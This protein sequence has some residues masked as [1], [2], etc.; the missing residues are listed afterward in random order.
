MK[1]YLLEVI[2]IDKNSLV[3]FLLGLASCLLFA[4][5]NFF[6]L[7]FIIFPILA[8]RLF[9]AQTYSKT[10]HILLYFLLGFYFSNYY[11]ISFSFLV[12]KKYILLFPIVFLLI[13]IYFSAVSALFLAL[14]YHIK[15]YLKLD[16]KGFFWFFSLL[17]FLHEYLRG[18]IV[19]LVDFKGFPWSLLGYSFANQYLMQIV[20]IIGVY[21]LTFLVIFLY[22]SPVLI[23]HYGKSYLSISLVILGNMLILAALYIFGIN[24]IKNAKTIEISQDKI[25]LLHSNIYKH[26]QHNPQ[27]IFDRV[28][29][30]ISLLNN[31]DLKQHQIIIL[32]EG[33][34]SVMTEGDE[35]VAMK[36]ILDN[37]K[38]NNINYLLAGA[39]YRMVD[40]DFTRYYNSFMVVA[41]NGKILEYY[42]KVNLVPFGEYVPYFNILPRLAAQHNFSRGKE[43]KTLAIKDKNSVDISFVPLICYDGV[44]S[45]KMS[46]N[47]DFLLNITNDI[48]FT[49]KI[50]SHNISLGTW[51]HFDQI[52]FRAVEEGKPL[53][54]SANYGIS[55][56]VDSFG[57]I[58]KKA[59]FNDAEHLIS[60]SLPEKLKN[61]SF[62]NQYRNLILYLLL[63]VSFLF[64]IIKIMVVKKKL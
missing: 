36:Y 7:G 6:I 48:W 4:P 41:S 38:D 63:F 15:K 58:I 42:N 37:L 20:S 57:R 59:D 28:S 39:P 12:N 26:H 61:K 14:I 49:K 10:F 33:A 45:G 60:F 44:F 5:F 53:V 56:V 2:T 47:G 64:V 40:K 34:I 54:R 30:I 24:H 22:N 8:L 52:R 32:P 13:P 51:Q 50:F 27:I 3:V 46:K 31:S 35:N 18:H 55:A 62:F 17:L 16:L 21:G 11:W 29:N 25:L 19:P 43:L 1:R 9:A 23:Y